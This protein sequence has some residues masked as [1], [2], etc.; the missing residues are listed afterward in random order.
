M[1]YK[2]CYGKCE[3]CVWFKNGGCSEWNGVKENYNESGERNSAR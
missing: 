1:N 3:R 2:E